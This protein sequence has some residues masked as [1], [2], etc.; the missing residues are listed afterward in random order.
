[1]F[2][3]E[4]AGGESYKESKN[5]AAGNQAVLADLPWARLGMTICYDLRFAY[6]Y[7]AL[8][9]NGAQI[10]TVPA[11]FTQQ[12]GQAHWHTLLKARAIE[13]GLLRAWR[14]PRAVCTTMDGRPMAT[15]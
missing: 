4:L 5:F 9:Q 7:R 13:T 12:T 8:A 2:D 15:A 10:L 3:V 6:V 14:Q 11:A 1:M